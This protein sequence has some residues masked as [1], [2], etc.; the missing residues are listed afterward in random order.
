MVIMM[1][2]FSL[3]NTTNTL[4]SNLIGQNEYDKIFLLIKRITILA[5]TINVIML[6]INVLFP[7]QII[8][9][10]T[11]DQ[12][13]IKE[14][15]NTLY[16]ISLTMFVFSF[17]IIRFSAISGTGNTLIALKIEIISI[18]IYLLVAFTAVKY[19]IMPVEIVWCSEFIYF[20]VLGGISYYF[21]K[22]NKLKEINI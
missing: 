7:E 4:V 2:I 6:I 12:S 9:V 13:L 10:Y 22:K 8:G 11:N 3:S 5:L 18:A 16:I 20:S 1:P 15:I 17:A 19:F 21:L 14:A